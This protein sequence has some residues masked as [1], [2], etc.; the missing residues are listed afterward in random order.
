M[1]P[2]AGDRNGADVGQ[3]LALDLFER[4]DLC[5]R[6]GCDFF[7]FLGLLGLKLLKLSQGG[8][9][10]GL[11]AARRGDPLLGFLHPPL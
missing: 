6:S 5:L 1:C 11:R 2:V 9:L 10:F 7:E 4:L 8:L 3:L